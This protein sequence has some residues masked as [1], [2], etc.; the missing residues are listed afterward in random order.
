MDA[1]ADIGLQESPVSA[2]E[3]A[4]ITSESRCCQSRAIGIVASVL[5]SL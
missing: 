4:R 2:S 5:P 3:G 1:D